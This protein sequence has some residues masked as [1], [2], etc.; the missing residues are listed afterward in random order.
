VSVT[1]PT[2][3]KVSVDVMFSLPVPASATMVCGAYLLAAL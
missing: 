1:L 2:A 3:S